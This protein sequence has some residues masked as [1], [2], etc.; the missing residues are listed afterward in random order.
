MLCGGLL[1]ELLTF[2]SFLFYLVRGELPVS[3]EE[4]SLQTHFL[5]PQFALLLQIIYIILHK[6]YYYVFLSPLEGLSIAALS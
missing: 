1:S 5:P 4:L 6:Q 3:R 2:I